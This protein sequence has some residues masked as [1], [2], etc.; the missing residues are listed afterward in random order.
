MRARRLLV[1]SCSLSATTL[2]GC[3]DPLRPRPREVETGGLELLQ[4]IPL[5]VGGRVLFGY[6]RPALD[7]TT[8]YAAMQVPGQF[9]NGV[10]VAVDRAT[11]T[12]RWS[13]ERPIGMPRNLPLSDG[14]VFLVGDSAVA[15]DAATG[16]ERWRMRPN[17]TGA[18]GIAAAAPGTAYFGTDSLV[19]A[20]ALA[21]GTERW[22]R[23]VVGPSPFRSFVRGVAVADDDVVV[24]IE[25]WT[26]VAGLTSDLHVV[27]LDRTTGTERWRH[28]ETGTD[29]QHLA[30]EEAA[31]GATEVIAADVG[32]N[33]LITLERGTGAVRWRWT[34][35]G[36][37]GPLEPP[38][39]VGDTVFAGSADR[40]V[41]A[42]D[43]LSGSEFWSFAAGAPVRAIAPCGSRV[44]SSTLLL[45]VLD[46][47][48][49]E[50]LGRDVLEARDVPERLVTSRFALDSTEAWFST[51][52]F[53]IGVLCPVE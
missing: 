6:T 14:I 18:T 37:A 24:T 7:A 42:L 21:D 8:V 26:H 30:T 51:Q 13:M 47:S 38:F 41:F 1:L 44:L 32:A 5:N 40:H 43:R 39:I 9:A 4:A 35:G 17:A 22:R 49:G 33:Q 31:I 2:L 27:M 12:L 20:L 11:G 34:G 23:A 52:G 48:T 15:Y 36:A 46:R 10:V 28:I 45:D 53:L 19:Y 50:P 25:A 3:F 29:E 16:V